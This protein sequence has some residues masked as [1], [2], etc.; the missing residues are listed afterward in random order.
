MCVCVFGFVLYV[1]V[2]LKRRNVRLNQ[3]LPIG[4]DCSDDEN[5]EDA[6]VYRN[7]LVFL[8]DTDT[9]TLNW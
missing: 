8:C 2:C 3:N 7:F 9:T 4:D 5:M 1:W 6:F